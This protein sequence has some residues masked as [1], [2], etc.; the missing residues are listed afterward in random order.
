MS[1]LPFSSSD[2]KYRR[3]P[4]S[5][6]FLPKNQN[7]NQ[8]RSDESYYESGEIGFNGAS[9]SGAV[10]NLSTTIVGAG[11]MAL[12]AT[13]KELGLLP[14]LIMIV[15]MAVLTESSIEI[16]LRFGK[17][18][19]SVSYS[20]VVGDSFGGGGRT[21]LQI[22]VI[23]NN[24]GLLI[25]YMII[26]GD[27]MSGT[28]LSSGMVHHSGVLEEWF[29]THWWTSPYVIL[30]F[31]AL[32]VISPL[33]SFKRVDSLRYTSALSVALAVVFVA[34]MTGITV[35]KLMI[36]SIEMPR[37]FP[38]VVDQ[39]SFWKLFTTVPVLVTAYIC[40]YSIH[41][42]ENEL[43]DP[44]QMKLIVRASLTFC[45]SVYVATSLFG[46]LLFGEKTL[47]D[48]LANF[49]A[50]LGIPYAGLLLNDV[51][52]VS[53]GLHLIL[54]FPVVFFSL[55]LSVDGLLFPTAVPIVFDN[56]RFLSISV[57]LMGVIFIGA[58]FV[59]NIW[60]AFQFTGATAATSLGFIFPAAIVLKDQ[61][62]IAT[63][64]DRLLS[65]FLMIL[66]VTSSTIAISSNIYSIFKD[67]GSEIMRS[68][69]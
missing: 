18:S 37:L 58:T 49:D 34:I 9:F 16:I 42:I 23:V 25:V 57:G 7:N 4:K 24:L 21:L 68:E 1:I 38:K 27:V 30:L 35:V 32:T 2:K 69:E 11:I 44:S 61:Y 47:D 39:A 59:P 10:F 63:K 14:G 3:S 43:K 15:V 66:A 64:K 53:Y 41:P 8:F 56:R 31:T 62:G 40:H 45:A 55:R 60:T 51:V 36:G 6:P 26:I 22:C 12:P 65:W 28:R 48:V 46:F 50:D 19:K 52:R 20:G 13:V 33:I 67:Q 17:A 5:H 29:G 54:V